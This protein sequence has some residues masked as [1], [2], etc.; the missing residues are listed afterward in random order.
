MVPINLANSSRSHFIQQTP[1]SY[2]ECQLTTSGPAPAHGIHRA[3]R[4]ENKENDKAEVINQAGC[5]NYASCEVLVM[6]NHRKIL[7]HGAR[8]AAEIAAHRIDNPDKQRS[9]ESDHGCNKLVFGQRRDE[10]AERQQRSAKKKNSRISS[11]KH[12][13]CP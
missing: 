1:P 4:Q 2:G 6:A 12:A 5:I 7:K 11:D 3:N 8:A 13:P 9:R 10:R